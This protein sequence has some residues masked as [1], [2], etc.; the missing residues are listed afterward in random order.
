MQNGNELTSIYAIHGKIDFD[1]DTLDKDPVVW[2]VISNAREFIQ[3]SE[4]PLDDS[5][6]NHP[7]TLVIRNVFDGVEKHI[8]IPMN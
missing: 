7:I 3:N 6:I 1:S 8:E 2:S 4:D 5:N